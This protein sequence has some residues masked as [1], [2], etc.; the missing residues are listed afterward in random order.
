VNEAPLSAQELAR[1]GDRDMA[2]IHYRR[3]WENR[4]RLT[5]GSPVVK[6]TLWLAAGLA[7]LGIVA[8]VVSLVI[9]AM[10]G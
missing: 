9:V 1:I 7:A 6:L 3:G 4:M 2:D 8:L 10:Q 5:H